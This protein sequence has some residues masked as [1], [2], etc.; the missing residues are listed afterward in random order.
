MQIY[1]CPVEYRTLRP[2]QETSVRLNCQE[3][4]VLR[5]QLKLE[6]NE[7]VTVNFCA[8]ILYVSVHTPSGAS[9]GAVSAESEEIYY[10]M[11]N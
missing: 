1:R 7:I 9:M 2:R 4:S 8:C 10:S 11:P 5:C 6:H 3:S